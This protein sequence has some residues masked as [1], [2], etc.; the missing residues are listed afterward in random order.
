M[1][2]QNGKLWKKVIE[3]HKTM[4]Y[5]QCWYSETKDDADKYNVDIDEATN[6]KN[7]N[8]IVKRKL[9]VTI[10]KQSIEK[11]GKNTK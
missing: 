1:T 4:G 7:M 3:N 5:K 10:E 8:G 6:K 9:R 2:T 11:E